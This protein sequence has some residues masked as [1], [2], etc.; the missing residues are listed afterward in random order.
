MVDVHNKNSRSYNMSQIKGKDT[1]PEMKVRRFLHANGF[2][3]RLHVRNL[4]GL[5]DIV[6]NKY[7]TVIFVHG[8]F[9]HRHPNCRYTTNPKSNKD[10]WQAK[11]QVNVE[12]DIKNQILLKQE[13]WNVVLIWECQLKSKTIDK[14]FIE[15]IAS[16]RRNI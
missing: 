14:S 5:P 4:P 12:N 16:I 2:R 6:L 9:W 7:R 13:G 3:F 1:Q 8:C 11:F 15:I 10:Y